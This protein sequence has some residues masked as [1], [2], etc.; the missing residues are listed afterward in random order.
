MGP[1]TKNT[2]TDPRV[3]E[4]MTSGGVEE[5]HLSSSGDDGVDYKL[6][7]AQEVRV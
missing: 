2:A 5:S 6:R 7:V 4:P 1:S 3:T